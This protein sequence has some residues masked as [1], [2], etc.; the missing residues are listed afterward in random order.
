[1]PARP[2]TP[3]DTTELGEILT[4]LT[5]N[6]SHPAIRLI[7]HAFTLIAEDTSLT[8]NDTQVL[9]AELAGSPDGTDVLAALGHLI[10]RLTNPDS[11]PALRTLPNDAQKNAQMEGEQTAR[12]LTHYALRKHPSAAIAALENRKDQP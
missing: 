3:L 2:V 5:A 1:M 12:T 11:N 8:P 4:D 7:A 9:L 6:P 10:A